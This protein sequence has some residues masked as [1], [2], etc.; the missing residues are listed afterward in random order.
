MNVHD[1]GAAVKG[2]RTEIA[3][4]DLEGYQIL[5]FR[6]ELSVLLIGDF[7]GTHISPRV[8]MRRLGVGFR[9]TGDWVGTSFGGAGG[10]WGQFV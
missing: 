4:P 3:C 10:R 1:C 8:M 9:E 2:V 5:W 7:V 6:G